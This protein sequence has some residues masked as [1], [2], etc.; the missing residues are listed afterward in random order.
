MKKRIF[1]SI[2]IVGCLCF[3]V[4][5][6]RAQSFDWAHIWRDNIVHEAGVFTGVQDRD[7]MKVSCKLTG[8]SNPDDYLVH[9]TSENSG[10]IDTYLSSYRNLGGGAY[11]FV[12]LL[13]RLPDPG[14]DWESDTYHFEIVDSDTKSIV[15]D[16]AEW[17][18]P[19]GYVTNPLDIP[20]WHAFSGDVLNPTVKWGATLSPGEGLYGLRVYELNPDGSFNYQA[21]SYSTPLF[22]TTTWILNNFTLENGKSYAIV[23]LS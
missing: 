10:F 2:F 23:I 13:S 1:I 3:H 8:V 16:S 14:P 7:S 6:V 18:I 11:E 4:Q 9:L 21:I 12:N 5:Y 19:T 17:T 15:Y 22:P 20:A